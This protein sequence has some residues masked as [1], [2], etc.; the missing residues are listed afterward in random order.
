MT[1]EPAQEPS[2]TSTAPVVPPVEQTKKMKVGFPPLISD[3]VARLLA[4]RHV[5]RKERVKPAAGLWPT[6]HNGQYISMKPTSKRERTV[7]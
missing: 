5:V 2:P 3:M 7:F 6:D 1:N 4:P